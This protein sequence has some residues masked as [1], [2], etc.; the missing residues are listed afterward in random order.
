MD[1]DEALIVIGNRPDLLR[2]RVAELRKDAHPATIDDLPRKALKALINEDA[3]P[4]VG[5]ALQY[6]W[7]TI[8]GFEAVASLEPIIPPLPSGR[9]GALT[10]LGYDVL[11]IPPIGPY[12][13][14]GM[15][16]R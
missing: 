2:M 5:G 7:A 4:T 6:G 9:N 3:D 15:T 12:V 16:G 13:P 14:W 10:V 1:D 8:N 11:E